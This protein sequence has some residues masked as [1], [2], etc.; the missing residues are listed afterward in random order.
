MSVLPRLVLL[1][2]VS[3]LCLVSDL[4]SVFGSTHFAFLP[5]L[6]FSLRSELRARRLALKAKMEASKAKATAAAMASTE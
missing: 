4:I 2:V 6:S 3:R 5:L 1:S